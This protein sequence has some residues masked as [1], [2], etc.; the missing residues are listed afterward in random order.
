MRLLTGGSTHTP[1]F[2]R[3]LPERIIAIAMHIDQIGH[4]ALPSKGAKGG[5][6]LTIPKQGTVAEGQNFANSQASS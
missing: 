3:Q 4:A 2:Q 6:V 5:T 1:E